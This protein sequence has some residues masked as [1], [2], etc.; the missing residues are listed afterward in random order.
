MDGS[1]Y[2]QGAPVNDCNHD[3]DLVDA[4]NDDQDCNDNGVTDVVA[5][6]SSLAEPAGELVVLD[7]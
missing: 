5:I 4:G 1:P 6:A 3:G 2:S 7:R